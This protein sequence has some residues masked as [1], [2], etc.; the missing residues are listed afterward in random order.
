MQV[1]KIKPSGFN[2][3]KKKTLRRF[4]PKML[5]AGAAGITIT[6]NNQQLSE[7]IVNP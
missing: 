6:V 1:F 2:E 4:I 3:I 7:T 5:I